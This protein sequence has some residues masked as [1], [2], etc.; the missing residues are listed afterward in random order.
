MIKN[1]VISFIKESLLTL[2]EHQI[3]DE[4]FSAVFKKGFLFNRKSE[5]NTVVFVVNVRIND[6]EIKC[7]AFNY[8]YEFDTSEDDGVLILQEKYMSF[9]KDFEKYVYSCINFIKD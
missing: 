6:V 1:N 5:E 2:A 9:V 4:S 3:D 8:T 7:Q